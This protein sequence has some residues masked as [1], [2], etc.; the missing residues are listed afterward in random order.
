MCEAHPC[1]RGYEERKKAWPLKDQLWPNE[2]QQVAFTVSRMKNKTNKQTTQGLL[3]QQ[4]KWTA[5]FPWG[6]M[7]DRLLLFPSLWK[8]GF[9]RT[10]GRSVI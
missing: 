9:E 5:S 4:K 3:Q 2:G 8:N 1:G 6:Q 10:V 7:W